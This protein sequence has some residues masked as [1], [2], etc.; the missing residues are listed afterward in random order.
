[1]IKIHKME[2]KKTKSPILNIH[3]MLIK[4]Y[5]MNHGFLTSFMYNGPNN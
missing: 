1:M 3:G 4:L 2:N 5:G